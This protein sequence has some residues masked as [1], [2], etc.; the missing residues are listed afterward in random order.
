MVFIVVHFCAFFVC[1]YFIIR[2]HSTIRYF[3]WPSQQSTVNRAISSLAGGVTTKEV[4]TPMVGLA[5]TS[6]DQGWT[7]SW[8]MWENVGHISRIIAGYRRSLDLDPTLGF[9]PYQ[10]GLARALF[11]QN[12]IADRHLHSQISQLMSPLC[13][14]SCCGIVVRRVNCGLWRWFCLKCGADICDRCHRHK[15]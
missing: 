2:H 10:K 7:V 15:V 11:Q 5:T 13:P 8:R 12:R 14:S 6:V 9:L 3:H 1:F 4:T